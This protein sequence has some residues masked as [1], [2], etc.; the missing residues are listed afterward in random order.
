MSR[1]IYTYIDLKQLG[2]NP[3]WNKIR[4]FPQI[5]V[6]SDLRKSLKGSREHDKVDGIFKEEAIVQACEIRMLTEAAFPK[7]RDD[8]TKFHE[9]V[10]LS[11]FIR[12]KLE[13][14]QGDP[15]SRRWLTGC[16]RN[17]GMILSS[18]ILLEEAGIDT[19]D[20]HPDGDRNMEFLL[21]AWDFLKRKDSAIPTFRSRIT[22]LEKRS[23]WDP[24][25][26]KLFGRT[27]IHT[28]VF[29]GFYEGI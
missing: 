3:Y 1:E 24:I 2:Q 18:I 5:T 11:Q 27:N 10:V 9:T 12:E 7:W 14:C 16:R 23:A 21:E 19:A 4:N 8:E 17:L 25:F 20:I 6:T 22:E 15:A 28:S 13:K 26:N 29:H